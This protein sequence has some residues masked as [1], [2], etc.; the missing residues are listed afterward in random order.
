MNF[1]TSYAVADGVGSLCLWGVVGWIIWKNPSS[2][3]NSAAYIFLLGFLPALL[4]SFLG[5]RS[6]NAMRKRWLTFN[7]PARL[8]GILAFLPFGIF[9]LGLIGIIPYLMLKDWLKAHF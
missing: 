2:A 8:I 5:A 3:S 9:I 6:L 4:A 7:W 1:F